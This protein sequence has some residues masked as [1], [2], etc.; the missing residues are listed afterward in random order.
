M[1]PSK[2]TY[3]YQLSKNIGEELFISPEGLSAEDILE[4]EILCLDEKFPRKDFSASFEPVSG[5]LII[6][7]WVRLDIHNTGV[8]VMTLFGDS[9]DAEKQSDAGGDIMHVGEGKI[10]V[11]KLDTEGAY[12]Y[13]YDGQK[14]Q[15]LSHFNSDDWYSVYVT[16]DVKKGR[17][18]LYLDGERVLYHAA[19]LQNAAKVDCVEAGTYGGKLYIKRLAV[20]QPVCSSVE[21]VAKGRKIFDVSKMGVAADGKEIVTEKLQK[22]IDECGEEKGIVYLKEGIYLSGMLELKDHVTLY[23]DEGATIKGV[24]DVEAYPT[25]LSI[26]HP[27]WNNYVQGPQ[28][29]LI[30]ADS[31]EDIAI[32]GG[33]T[34]DGSGDFEGAYGSESLRVCAILLIG[35]PG[36]RLE[37]LYIKDAGMWTVPLMECDDMYIH[38]ININSTWYPNRDGFDLCDCHNVLVEN[39]NIKAD[40]DAFCMKSGAERGCDRIYARDCFIIST[41]ANGIKFGTYSYGGFTNCTFTNSII[42]DTRTCGIVVQCVDGGRVENLEFD[43]IVIQNVESA[44]FILIGDKQR[45]PEGYERRIGSV[46]DI[47]FKNIKAD[48][49]RRSYGTYL[50]GFAKDGEVYPIENISFEKVDVVYK[51][52]ILEV[53]ATPEEFGLQYPESNCFGL[54]PASGY[55]IRHAKNVSFKDCN[56]IVALPDERDMIVIDD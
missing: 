37:E 49:L 53:P 12:F 8:N 52:G 16:I 40:D 42:K 11:I 46:K 32:L 54:L 17:Y 7:M 6:S 30:F 19:F 50:G 21:D 33:G 3:L 26:N 2:T 55:Y 18:S 15:K 39:C 25:K 5:K 41:M 35:C 23:I 20:Y 38:D 36:V 34:I 22:I 47:R 45:V 31:K 10:P 48:G 1:M 51:G 44:F 27:N 29:A 9:A 4:Q 14:K 13:A 28:K 24:L 43:E 56:T